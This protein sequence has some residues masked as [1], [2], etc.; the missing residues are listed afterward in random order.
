MRHCVVFRTWD[1]AHRKLGQICKAAILDDAVASE[2]RIKG[3]ATS[4]SLK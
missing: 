3:D 1:I 2:P 4:K